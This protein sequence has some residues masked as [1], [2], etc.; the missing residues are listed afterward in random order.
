MQANDLDEFKTATQL[1]YSNEEVAAYSYKS[2]LQ[3]E[4]PIAKINAKH[5]SSQAAKIQPQDMNGLE[6]S[7]LMSKGAF[8]MLTMNMWPAVGLCN[9]S[10]GKI[11]DI[12]YHPSH[13]PP[14]LPIAVTVQLDD[15]IGLS[16]SNEIPSLVPIVL[17]TVSVP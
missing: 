5:S 17:V 11:V 16:I 10:I 14:D 4:Q 8:A 9:G 15:Y 1:F 3:L 2:L 7:L 13:Q 6:P 12:I